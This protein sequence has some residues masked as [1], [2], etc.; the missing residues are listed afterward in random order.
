M[1]DITRYV[2]K[3]SEGRLINSEL[4]V[5]VVSLFIVFLPAKVGLVSVCL[6]GAYGFSLSGLKKKIFAQFS[7]FV[8]LF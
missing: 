1:S 3:V 6:K 4:F 8:P 7:L 5:D 2:F